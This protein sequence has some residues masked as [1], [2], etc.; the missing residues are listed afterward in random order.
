MRKYGRRASEKRTKNVLQ[1]IVLT[2][3]VP[4]SYEGCVHYYTY[5]YT[6]YAIVLQC[7]FYSPKFIVVFVFSSVVPLQYTDIRNVCDDKGGEDEKC[8]YSNNRASI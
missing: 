4:S 8:E 7:T 6:R 5:L 1:W 3:I 2:I